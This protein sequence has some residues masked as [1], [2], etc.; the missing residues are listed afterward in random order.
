MQES[1]YLST[2]WGLIAQV[3][4][5][6]RAQLALGYTCT[7]LGTYTHG[8]F[9][10]DYGRPLDRVYKNNAEGMAS[11]RGNS[12]GHFVQIVRGLWFSDRER[13]KLG[14]SLVFHSTWA[15]DRSTPNG[16]DLSVRDVNVLGERNHAEDGSM[17]TIATQCSPSTTRRMTSM[18]FMMRA[19]SSSPFE[20]MLRLDT[21]WSGIRRPH[22]DGGKVRTRRSGAPHRLVLPGVL[23]TCSRMR[24]R[25]NHSTCTTSARPRGAGDGFVLNAHRRRVTGATGVPR[26]TDADRFHARGPTRL[27]CDPF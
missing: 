23:I 14:Q 3:T 1:R 24:P 26:V 19:K 7:N 11:P 20:T 9:E 27:S 13:P 2:G 5:R 10:S 15:E 16:D 21:C 8:T 25:A 4:S 6:C 12:P 17:S 22:L 18:L